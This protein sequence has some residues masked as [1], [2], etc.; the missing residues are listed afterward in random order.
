MIKAIETRYKGYRF[1]SRLEA[2]WAVFFD[3]AGI[4]WQYEPQGFD[5][6]SD[7]GAYLPDFYLPASKTWVEIKPDVQDPACT[8]S[9]YLAG[10]V[11]QTCWR[12]SIVPGL[13]SA[14]EHGSAL[15][16]DPIYI[17]ERKFA[18]TGPFFA[19]CDHGCAHGPSTHGQAETDCTPRPKG[20]HQL[21]WADDVRSACLRAIDDA[22]DFFAWIETADCFGTLIEAGYAKARGKRIVVAYARGLLDSI[23][24]VSNDYQSGGAHDMW[25]LDSIADGMIVADSALD[26]FTRA[27]PLSK[28]ELE[29]KKIATVAQ[30]QHGQWLLCYG[31]PL[32]GSS[33]RSNWGFDPAARSN[34]LDAAQQARSARFEHGENPGSRAAK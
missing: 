34:W 22:S 3:A 5:L 15:Q 33:R 18:M 25:F 26:A 30:S 13:R 9:I 32:S 28:E 14:T 27:Y 19:S 8:R 10:K 23:K 24:R 31:D 21:D 1:R 20:H 7:L 16:W 12:H 29:L 11:S 4:D 2:R 6:G 17:G